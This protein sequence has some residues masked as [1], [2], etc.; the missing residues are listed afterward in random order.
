MIKLQDGLALI[1]NLDS[2]LSLDED[3]KLDASLEK[4]G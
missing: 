2:F 3:K 1:H 4:K